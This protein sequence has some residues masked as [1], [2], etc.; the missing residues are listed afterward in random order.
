MKKI[1][2]PALF[3]P[4][5]RGQHDI[6]PYDQDAIYQAKI[7]YEKFEE[8]YLIYLYECKY[9]SRDDV[10]VDYKHYIDHNIY[11]RRKLNQE[12]SNLE[13]ERFYTQDQA[14]SGPQEQT[15]NGTEFCANEISHDLNATPTSST[16]P[17]QARVHKEL[18]PE[19]PQFES[20]SAL[21]L[22]LE[23]PIRSF[24]TFPL[25]DMLTGKHDENSSENGTTAIGT[26]VNIDIF[27]NCWEKS[28]N[29][30]EYQVNQ[31][32]STRRSEDQ[33]FNQMVDATIFHSSDVN[34]QD[35]WFSTD[36]SL[37]SP[38]PPYIHQDIQAGRKPVVDEPELQKQLKS[39]ESTNIMDEVRQRT[40]TH[41]RR[42]MK[43]VQCNPLTL[44]VHH[45]EVSPDTALTPVE[46]RKD[47]TNFAFNP[48]YKCS[49]IMHDGNSY[50]QS[51]PRR[52]NAI[53]DC[54]NEQQALETADAVT[55][56]KTLSCSL[57]KKLIEHQKIRKEAL[58]EANT[59]NEPN[60]TCTLIEKVKKRRLTETES[61]Q[62]KKNKQSRSDEESGKSIRQKNEREQNVQTPSENK[63][64]IVEILY[65]TRY[66]DVNKL[67]STEREELNKCL[68]NSDDISVTL[69]YNNGTT[70]LSN[71][72]QQ[73]ENTKLKGIT[74]VIKGCASPDFKDQLII[75]SF[76]TEDA[77]FLNWFKNCFSTL[78][79]EKEIVAFDAQKIVVALIEVFDFKDIE[80]KETECWMLKDPLLGTWLLDADKSPKTLQDVFNCIKIKPISTQTGNKETSWF[81]KATLLQMISAMKKIREKLI[82]EN[83][84]KLFLVETALIPILACMETARIKIHMEKVNQ[85]S[86]I[87]KKKLS[88]L[89]NE[90]FKSVGHTFL[91]NSHPQLRQ[92]LYEELQL[93]KKLPANSK[94]VKTS[95]AHQKSTSESMLSQLTPYHPLPNIVLE[96]RQLQKLKST[97]VDG[98]LSCIDKGY[99]ST[100]WDQIGAA[101]GR[102]SSYHP[103]IQAIPKTCVTITNYQ[104]NFIEGKTDESKIDIYAR[105]PFISHDGW[106]LLAADFQQIELRLLAHLSNDPQLL[107]IFNTSNKED[108]FLTLTS[109]WLCKPYDRISQTE[110]EQTKRI[111]YSVMYG[112]G[113]DR[114]ADYLKVS[115]DNAK[116]I[117]NSFLIKFPAVNRFTKSC[118]Q[119]C[120]KHGFT[121]T[122]FGRRRYVPNIH[123]YNPVLR[124]Q[125]ERQCVNF[126]V[127][128]SAA[129]LCKA[130]MVQVESKLRQYNT[131][132]LVQI[133]DELVWEVPEKDISIVKD[134]IKQ[135]MEDKE[136]LCQDIASLKVPLSITISTGASWA[137]LTSP[138]K[139]TSTPPQDDKC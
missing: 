44:S 80:K 138:D 93:D 61:K 53:P 6:S 104:D 46:S 98:M 12:K 7:E 81:I 118:I 51:I 130:A 19:I 100:Y 134:T 105:E 54:T 13:Y 26:P 99:L 110:R 117:M 116:G 39:G 25:G 66:V 89:E 123:S 63:T 111:V 59:R 96:Y 84:Y 65:D 18:F 95:V 129:D 57:S 112:V 33:N 49:H 126:R 91:I 15:S 76:L 48:F 60:N 90:A 109:Q 103:N 2:R 131:R 5:I 69:L 9:L 58:V 24:N 139:L 102:L 56:P 74:L 113:K 115:P 124:A 16:W 82:S 23:D 64:E 35:S 101:T 119:F 52:Q 45:G 121:R 14:Q 137:H 86:S 79:K 122:L 4:R 135:A 114:L 37:T 75:F 72:H 43:P 132:L 127:Q 10:D 8:D 27:Q 62:K 40:R 34:Y 55:K 36:R 85:F 22:N 50:E 11:Y 31:N 133:H 47:T 21:Q 32:L 125:A 28:D 3:P 70:L 42:S 97:Y 20:P 136:L 107:E 67:P 108:I 77:E 94:L 1:W 41:N 71:G 30:S 92:V 106:L 68:L 17:Q 38:A 78:L 88:K 83:I 73:L 120:K 29:D 87:L 128:G